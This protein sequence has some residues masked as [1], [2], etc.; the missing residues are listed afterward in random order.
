M[1]LSY[2]IREKPG[3]LDMV[4]KPAGVYRIPSFGDG[5]ACVWVEDYNGATYK[6]AE[7]RYR[8]NGYK[9]DVDE[10]PIEE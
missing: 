3:K 1:P 5:P 6:I 9:P 10:L 7:E 4:D 8:L 2:T